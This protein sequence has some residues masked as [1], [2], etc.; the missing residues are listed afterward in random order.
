LSV[1][2]SRG[3]MD[4]SFGWSGWVSITTPQGVAASYV[5]KRL[6]PTEADLADLLASFGLPEREAD[7]LARDLWR[8]RPRRP[9]AEAGEPGDEAETAARRPLVLAACALAVVLAVAALLAAT[10]A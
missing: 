1:Q 9:E 2:S 7:S 8:R 3:A 10:F 5:A 6:V 4:V